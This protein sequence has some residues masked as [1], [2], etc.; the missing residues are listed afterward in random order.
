MKRSIFSLVLIGLLALFLVGCKSDDDNNP[1]NHG[2]NTSKGLIAYYPFSGNADDESG[3]G[4]HGIV[5]GSVLTLDR[6][7]NENSA[8]QFDGIDDVITIYDNTLLDITNDVT[9]MAWFKIHSKKTGQGIISKVNTNSRSPWDILIEEKLIFQGANA[10]RDDAFDITFP[11]TIESDQWIYVAGTAKDGMAKFYVNGI[12]TDSATYS[13]DLW[14]NDYDVYIGTRWT[15]QEVHFFNGCIDEV[16]IYNRALSGDEIDL[17]YHE[18][19]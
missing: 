6:L 8:Y 1:V 17:L 16:R 3:N 10:Y 11:D 13:G 2:T 15:H 9:I 19:E 12:I 14:N 5:S 7:G 18:G 4:L